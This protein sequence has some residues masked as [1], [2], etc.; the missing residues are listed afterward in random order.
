M[1]SNKFFFSPSR[2]EV[3]SFLVTNSQLMNVVL[4]AGKPPCK[5]SKR[6]CVWRCGANLRIFLRL[7]SSRSPLPG[8]SQMKAALLLILVRYSSTK[9]IRIIVLPDPVGDFTVIVCL[10]LLSATRS[11]SLSTAFS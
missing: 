4:S 10:L 1:R 6:F 8:Q 3:L 11:M 9:S 2:N 7:C 5:A